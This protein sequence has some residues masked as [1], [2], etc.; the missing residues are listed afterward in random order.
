MAFIAIIPILLLFVLLGVYK[1]PAVIVA[2]AIFIVTVFLGYF[3]YKISPSILGK[4]TLEGGVLAVYPILWVVISAVLIYNVSSHTIGMNIIKEHLGG[5]T[6]DKSMQALLIAFCFGGFMEAVAGFG[7]AVT[8]PASI[9]I[10]LGFNPKKAS[11]ICLLSNSVPVAFGA[12]GLPIITLADITVLEFSILSAHVAQQLFLMCILVPVL[13]VYLNCEDYCKTKEKLLPAV[14]CGMVYAISQIM[15]VYYL[16]GELAALTGSL[17]AGITIV[18]YTKVIKKN[19]KVDDK[20]KIDKVEI[21]KAWSP[22]LILI[23]LVVITRLPVIYSIISRQPFIFHFDFNV[24]APGK[25]LRFDFLVSPGTL[26]FIA[27]ISGGM[28]QGASFKEIAG[29]FVKTLGQLKDSIIVI[30]F[31]VALAKVMGYTGMIMDIAG[32]LVSISGDYYPFIAPATGALGTF[33]TGSDASSNI[34]FGQLQKTIAQ[35]IG[36]NVNWIVASNATGAT[37][38]KMISPQSLAIA[39]SITQSQGREGELFART[40]TYCLGYLVLLGIIVYIFA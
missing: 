29:V 39:T 40:I 22:Y 20:G 6:N 19:E 3:F 12:L 31:I 24:I 32:L 28:I 9:L 21:L 26:M 25:P 5:I 16:G 36:R 8:I 7:T 4:A 14:L 35:R 11:V 23:S 30:I 37:A 1:K 2:P 13:I 15:T 27:A 10:S 34:L 18:L 17:F 38:G 33:L